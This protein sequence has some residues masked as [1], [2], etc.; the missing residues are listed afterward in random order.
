MIL[1]FSG[2]GNSRY[3]ASIIARETGDELVCMNDLMRERIGDP[4]NARYSFSS[5]APFVFV[6]PTYCYR[7][8]R[9]VEQFL[10]RS[11][12]EGSRQAYFYLTCGDS[13]G[14]AAQEAERLCQELELTF[15]GL[16]SVK[17]PENYIAMFE[18][19]S[20]DDALGILR[21]ATS[22]IE[23][24]GR[25]IRFGKPLTDTNTGSA[26]ITR[27]NGAFYKLFVSDKKYKVKDTCIGC[28]Q[29]QRV[30]PLANIQMVDGRP[31]WN[32]NCT[33]C[34]ACIGIC[35]QD[36][37]EYGRGTHGKRRYYLFADGRQRD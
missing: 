28:G 26:F 31:H 35:P 36:A 18:A 13:T 3:A 25:M 23:S 2:T 30:C 14:A 20:Y 5:E 34:M 11:R 4:Y 17:M 16:G 32:G 8:P 21:A 6:C 33:Q 7:V 1:Y 12:F 29:C 24:A 27:L 37:I 15:M 10:R 22:Q 9:V 19:P